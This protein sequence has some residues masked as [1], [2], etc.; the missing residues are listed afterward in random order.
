L[1]GVVGID[2]GVGPKANACE[3][4]PSE[5][6]SNPAVARKKIPRRQ[7]D[8]RTIRRLLRDATA[9]YDCRALISERRFYTRGRGPCLP[10]I[11]QIERRLRR[12][13]GAKRKVGWIPHRSDLAQ[14][15]VP[16]IRIVGNLTI[17]RTFDLSCL[18][19]TVSRAGP[20]W[21]RSLRLGSC[22]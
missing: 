7:L 4:T 8:K 21:S 10:K 17:A 1:A 11:L 14:T 18:R 15:I 20:E 3:P 9:R 6:T 5:P 12:R 13:R 22:C 2:A 16:V 19:P